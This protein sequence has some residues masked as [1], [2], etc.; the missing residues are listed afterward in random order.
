MLLRRILLA[1]LLLVAVA[2]SSASAQTTMPPKPK[3]TPLFHPKKTKSIVKFLGSSLYCSACRAFSEELVA[4]VKVE[5]MRARVAAA[6]KRER[7]SM[8]EELT[9]F[10]L[11]R[12]GPN[13]KEMGRRYGLALRDDA[14][15]EF[16]RL[17]YR[18]GDDMQAMM[19]TLGDAHVTVESAQKLQLACEHFVEDY[20]DA[21]ARVLFDAN[22]A[23]TKEAF[24]AAFC[25]KAVV[26]CGRAAPG[27]VDAGGAGSVC[28][29]EA[30]VI[31]PPAEKGNEG[32]I[33]V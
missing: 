26:A 23:A 20:E 2:Q 14:D 5:G 17:M 7:A 32:V 16:K 6:P 21:L 4:A 22:V 18:D 29:D 28:A 24:A 1:A 11:D 31:V 30:S 13:C 15:F 8:R 25:D 12:M 9:T 10:F 27:D 19:R 3:K 33:I